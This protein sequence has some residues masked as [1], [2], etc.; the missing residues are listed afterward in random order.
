V[1]DVRIIVHIFLAVLLG[2]TIW[3]L[4]SY[5]LISSNQPQL[6]HLGLAMAQQY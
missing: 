5:W 6:Q 4:G 2:G 1:D 3:R